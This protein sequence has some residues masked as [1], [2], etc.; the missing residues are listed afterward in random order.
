M[1][2]FTQFMTNHLFSNKYWNMSLA[3]MYSDCV[4]D[5]TGK[6]VEDLDQVLITDLSLSVF[7]FSTFLS[8]LSAMKG[9]FFSERPMIM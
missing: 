4:T 5:I 3:I 9:P 2:K 7:C 8:R 1:S 6:I